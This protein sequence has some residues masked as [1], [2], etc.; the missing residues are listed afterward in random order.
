ML[1]LRFLPRSR[2]GSKIAVPKRSSKSR[3][4]RPPL[5]LPG[6]PP[7]PPTM[8]TR[9]RGAAR[10]RRTHPVARGCP[11]RAFPPGRMGQMRIP[12]RTLLRR[13]PRRPAQCR[14]ND[15]R[16]L[17]RRSVRLLPQSLLLLLLIPQTTPPPL[18]PLPPTRSSTPTATAPSLKP[19]AA[20]APSPIPPLPG[21]LP[22]PRSPRHLPPPPP[23]PP[24]LSAVPLLRTTPTTPTS[25]CLPT[26]PPRARPIHTITSPPPTSTR[27]A[28]HRFR[29]RSRRRSA[30]MA[31]VSA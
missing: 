19:T 10:W 21:P 24:L 31:W 8:A 22:P 23:L 27:S 17:L 7:P 11:P 16:T 3:R 1:I 9:T 18:P 29:P 12:Q 13:L 28:A 15:R 2:S 14:P 4:Q 6:R 26:H 30:A 20:A 25:A 5:P